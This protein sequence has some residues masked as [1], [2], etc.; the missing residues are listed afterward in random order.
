MLVNRFAALAAVLPLALTVA[1]MRATVTAEG[2]PTVV[3]TQA[4]P[5]LI[6]VITVDQL[7]GDMLD[8]Y[9]AHLSKGYARLMSGGAW[10]TNAHQ[11]HATTET[12]PGHASVLSGRFPRSTGILSN[13]IGVG[14]RNYPLI[15]APDLGASPNRFQGTGLYD[16]IAARD[17]RARALSVSMK[18]RSAILPIGKSKQEIYWYASNGTFTTSSYYRDTLPTWVQRFNARRLP[19]SYA[20]SHWSLSMRPEVYTMPDSVVFENRGQDLVFAHPY[21]DTARAVSYV[22]ATPAMDSMTALFALEGLRQTG[23]GQGPHT[24]ILALGLSGTDVI[25][26]MWGPD[27]REAFENEVRLD[28][29]IGWFLDSLFTMRDP[30]TI[31]IV[32]TADHGVQ[33]IP[34]L[35]RMRGEAT[36]DQGLRISLAPQVAAVRK[37]L[38]VAGADTTAFHYEYDLI[39]VDRD[40]LAAARVNADSLLDAFAAAVRK[41]P[42]VARVDR[43]SA[44]HRTDPATDPIARR[45]AHQL[46]PG[47]VDLVITLTRY[48]YWGTTPA[49]HG[50]PYDLDAHVPII[51]HG[52]WFAPG[53]YNRF[54]RT[55][56]I[57]PTLAQIVGVRPLERVD[58]LVLVEAIRR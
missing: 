42:G 26:H 53:R 51:F 33:P 15:G 23:I 35:A 1:C 55:V 37:S 48:S 28:Q 57:G 2:V 49:T 52:P 44:I 39:A 16:W 31:A 12:A 34:E 58:G 17:S 20:G 30:S 29:T 6:V 56:D 8:R 22:R 45:W 9:R 14:D 18:D 54:V 40:K 13:S 5:R 4:P 41:V 21:G 43:L 25:G 7:R 46:P 32:L 11:D 19:Q 36:G 50:S 38:A 10:F 24:D 47:A 27:S 3:A